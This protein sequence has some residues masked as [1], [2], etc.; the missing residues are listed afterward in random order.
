MSNE[1][2][3]I[4]VR[5]L[6]DGDWMWAH[7]NVLFSQHISASEFKVY[8]GLSSFSNNRSQQS[9]PSLV[10]LATRLNMSKSTVIR[11]MKVLELCGLISIDRRDGNSNLYS[12]LNCSEIKPATQPKQQSEHHKLID[13]F[14]KTAMHFR[15]VKPQWGPADFGALK[16]TLQAGILSEQEIEQLIIY[17]MASP[18]YK[19][20]GP[21]MV[22]FFSAGIF[23]G[24]MND[25][26][27]R[28]T[29]WKDLDRYATEFYAKPAGV[30]R[31]DVKKLSDM[32]ATLSTNMR[33]ARPAYAEEEPAR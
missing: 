5:D 9:W 30:V 26:K 27:N 12:L 3:K 10:T 16:R 33:V 13:V 4:E 29:F 8:C 1:N 6:R 22:T 14:Q 32:M 21:S 20:F 23:T 17:F 15:K 7:K 24:L 11:S 19:K 18:G 31:F 25:A 2:P 28:E